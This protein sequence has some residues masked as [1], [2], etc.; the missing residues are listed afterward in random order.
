MLRI[1][2][3]PRSLERHGGIQGSARVG[4]AGG[5]G[6]GDDTEWARTTFFAIAPLG[7]F[8]VAASGCCPIVPSDSSA[9]IGLRS[10]GLGMEEA[11]MHVLLVED[12]EAFRATLRHL[13]TRRDHASGSRRRPTARR[14][15]VWSRS[16][17]PTSGSWI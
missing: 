8:S 3:I 13:L 11:A 4:L 12:D 10:S 7:N 5:V 15:W 1:S 14:P 16:A 6:P 2:A 9:Y 17:R